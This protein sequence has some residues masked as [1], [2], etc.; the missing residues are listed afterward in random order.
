MQKSQG[1]GGVP[2]TVGDGVARLYTT[3]NV[4]Y[5]YNMTKNVDPM[6]FSAKWL[7]SPNDHFGQMT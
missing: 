3:V 6:T 4:I 7:L 5:R 1:G 2:K